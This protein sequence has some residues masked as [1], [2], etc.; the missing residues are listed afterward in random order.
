MA[1]YSIGDVV[2][3]GALGNVVVLEVFEATANSQEQYI[4]NAGG[5]TVR[6]VLPAASL[7]T[8][9]SA[10]G[11]SSTETRGGTDGTIIQAG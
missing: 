9:A 5:T 3:A 1:A 2:N 4:V 11:Q 8:G 10:T 7:V 6:T